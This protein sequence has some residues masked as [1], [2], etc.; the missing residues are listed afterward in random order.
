VVF[1]LHAIRRKSVYSSPTIRT[2]L[3]LLLLV[4][5]AASRV[6][7]AAPLEPPALRI[8][9]VARPP[10]LED[11][12]RGDIT[13]DL[14]A[15]SDFRQYEPGDGIKPRYH[16]SAF[17]GYDDAF[18]YVVFVCE[19]EPGQ[20]RARLSAREEIDADD[21]VLVNLDTFHDRQR[22]YTFVSNP[23]GVQQDY[24][25]S[26]EQPR[27]L[28]FDALWYSQ[29]R[30]TEDGFVVWMAIPFR[31]LRFPRSRFQTWAIAFARRHVRYNEQDTWPFISRRR[32]NYLPQMATLE[33]LENISPGRNVQLTPYGMMGRARFLDTNVPAFQSQTDARAGLDSKIVLRDSLSLDLALNPDFSQVES[34]EPQVTVNQRFE[35]FFPERRPFFIENASYFD[36]PLSLRRGNYERPSHLFFSRRLADPQFGVRLTGKSGPWAIG[37]LATDDRSLGQ[38]L[39]ASHVDFGRNAAAGALRL[40]REFAG[41]SSLGMLATSRDFAG[42]F[43]RLLSFDARLKINHNWLLAAQAMQSFTH[44]HEGEALSGPGYYARFE[45][46]GRHLHY[47]SRYT[48]L[49]PEFRAELGFIRRVDIRQMEHSAGYRWIPES[50]RLV[51]LE[52]SV[53]A[54]LNWDRQGRLQDWI[55]GLGLDVAFTRQTR[56]N[57]WRNESFELYE[58]RGF[59]KKDAGLSF[60]TDWLP[61]VGGSAS[62]R[63]GRE[64]NYDP[65]AGLRPFAAAFQEGGLVLTMRPAPRLRLVHRYIYNRLTGAPGETRPAVIFNNHIV[66]WRCHYQFT[67]RLSLRTILDY[68]AVLPNVS[69]VSLEPVKRVTGDVLLTYL[70]HPGTALYLGYN[71]RQENLELVRAMPAALRRTGAPG[72]STGRQLF[73]KLTYLFR[74]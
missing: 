29:G 17:I 16:T 33:G 68:D 20:V 36:T 71:D 74:F 18:L 4:F 31:S 52:P 25:Y 51:G 1:H 32:G 64:V 73:M 38:G 44:D 37:A 5:A 69:L 24:I 43:N 15:V 27:E 28:S 13:P 62:Y 2:C 11:F 21:R 70:V 42:S 6:L 8:Q 41:Q 23:L 19:D 40:R 63:W 46:E 56:L 45:H 3:L 61:W 47:F 50:R 22:A 65:A 35:V 14:T 66:R 72:T 48:D 54:L 59:R 58:G 67:R 10:L 12:L 7:R 49:S 34:D 26:P 60:G 53:S 55:T 39:E 57:A 9:R 30:L